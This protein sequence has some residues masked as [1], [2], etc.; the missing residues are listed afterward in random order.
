MPVADHLFLTQIDQEY[1]GDVYFPPWE[2]I[3][4]RPLSSTTDREKGVGLEFLV[5]GKNNL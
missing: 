5:L 2:R 4:N 1:E 3:F